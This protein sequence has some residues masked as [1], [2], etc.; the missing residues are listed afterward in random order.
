MGVT[1]VRMAVC[2]TVG[3]PHNVGMQATGGTSPGM[4]LAAAVVVRMRVKTR[5]H[6]QRRQITCQ[7][8]CGDESAGS[9]AGQRVHLHDRKGNMSSGGRRT[10]HGTHFS[11]RSPDPVP[12]AE[13]SL[14]VSIITMELQYATG[15][16]TVCPEL[17]DSS[18]GNAHRASRCL[19]WS[20]CCKPLADPAK[21]WCRRGFPQWPLTSDPSARWIRIPGRNEKSLPE[22]PGISGQAL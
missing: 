9:L 14:T 11:C 10:G 21:R 18:C 20:M 7:A 1:P 6:N 3:R 15:C 16:L 2:M 13:A 8:E 5:T 19:S 22:N 4:C 17:A 12:A